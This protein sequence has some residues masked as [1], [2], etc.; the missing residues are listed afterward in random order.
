MEVEGREERGAGEGKEGN[1]CTGLH[2]GYEI[3]ITRLQKQVGTAPRGQRL[4]PGRASKGTRPGGPLR[5]L[6]CLE[7]RAE[8]VKRK[9][10]QTSSLGL[11]HAPRP[12]QSVLSHLL[13]KNSSRWC[14]TDVQ[15]DRDGPGL[16]SSPR[17]APGSLPDDSSTPFHPF[18]KAPPAALFEGFRQMLVTV[19]HH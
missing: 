13:F 2:L 4:R 10:E 19:V 17:A 12:P 14:N 18:P 15:V 9:E 1:L 5:D 3:F 6:L 8:K 7:K 16:G 11:C